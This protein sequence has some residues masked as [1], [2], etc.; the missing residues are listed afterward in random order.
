MSKWF[1][2]AVVLLLPFGC[3][4]SP[5]EIG[6]RV[7]KPN[8]PLPEIAGHT[9]YIARLRNCEYVIVREHSLNANVTIV[10]AG[11]CDN[12]THRQLPSLLNVCE[13]GEGW[14]KVVIPNRLPQSSIDLLQQWRT[15]G[16]VRPDPV[17]KVGK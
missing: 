9:A 17:G 14:I 15:N 13:Q 6:S 4:G 11:D 7:L 12:E 5:V 2:L 10:H 8:W 3:E 16:V 1:V